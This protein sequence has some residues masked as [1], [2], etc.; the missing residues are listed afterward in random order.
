MINWCKLGHHKWKYLTP[1]H[2]VCTICKYKEEKLFDGMDIDSQVFGTLTEE[3][4][5]LINDCLL[6]SWASFKDSRKVRKSTNKELSTSYVKAITAMK[7]GDKK[8]WTA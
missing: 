8:Q 6:S 5:P 3:L 4:R 1:D 7:V 2:R